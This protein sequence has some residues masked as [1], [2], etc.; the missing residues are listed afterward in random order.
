MTESTQN[1][2]TVSPAV[3]AQLFDCDESMIRYLAKKG[4]V[5]KSGHGKYIVSQ[6]VRNYIR[7]LRT[8][9][10]GRCGDEEK[11]TTLTAEKTRYA[12]EQ[13]DSLALKNQ[14]MR[15]ELVNVEDVQRTWA[16]AFSTI[17]SGVLS[18]V[19]ILPTILAHMT[20]HDIETVDRLL[21]DTLE[22]I[23]DEIVANKKR[24]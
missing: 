21:R 12:K 15:G 8:I 16:G 14:I 7:H 2:G 5:I 18:V 4:I 23:A 1:D 17:R 3:L 22:S 10:S 6:S 11:Q 19:S 24:S 9:A 13:A 20:R